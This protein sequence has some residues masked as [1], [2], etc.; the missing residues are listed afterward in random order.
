MIEAR[1]GSFTI[2]G[3]DARA[4]ARRFGTPLFVYDADTVRATY[5]RIRASFSYP[6]TRLHFAAVCNPNL[7]LL[8]VL[9]EAGAGLHANTPGDVFC[10]LRAGFD[11]A[12]IVFS[13]SNVGGEDLRYLVRSG[14]HINVDSLDD[15]AR[16]FSIAPGRPFGLRVHLGDVLPESRIGLREEEI[17]TAIALVTAAGGAVNALHVYCGT[18]GQN[19]ERYRRALDRLVA[20]AAELPDLDCINLGGGFGY[21]YNDPDHRAFP[22][23]ELGSAADATLRECSRRA[24]RAVTL[25]AEPGRALVAASGVML[26]QVRS[27]KFG[28]DRRYVG[29]DATVANLTSPAVH[30]AHRRVV[31]VAARPP[32]DGVADV[33]GC[34]TYSRD[35]LAQKVLMP[36]VQV[37]DVLAVL[38]CGAY[39]YCM[40]SHFLNRPRPAEVFVDG[41]EAVLVTRR[42]TFEDLIAMQEYARS[43]P[44]GGDGYSRPEVARR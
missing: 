12:D 42:E 38:D 37:G 17:G 18:H 41:G 27:V 1:E 8:R 11:P 32:K 43:T 31:S 14:V 26:T 30:G 15:L 13:G 9:R 24:G 19:L 3:L 29:V 34:T 25:K 20:I 10:G 39:G 40:S 28:T 16:A 4:L 36:D 22:F 33:C 7:Y 35:L 44:R 21:D 23:E 5:A 6:V 2:G